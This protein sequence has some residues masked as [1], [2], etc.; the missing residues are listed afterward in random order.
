MHGEERSTVVLAAAHIASPGPRQDEDVHALPLGREDARV[1]E[2]PEDM[3][4]APF[5][6]GVRLDIFPE[7]R[8]SLQMLGFGTH[9]M[10]D[11]RH[12]SDVLQQ[13]HYAC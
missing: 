10:P 4:R 13:S 11:G 5:A 12:L 2:V 7:S 9:S 8:P 6:M 3:M 1:F